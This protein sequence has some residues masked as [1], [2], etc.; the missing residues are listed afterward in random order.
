MRDYY[1]EW[2]VWYVDLSIR[3][4]AVNLIAFFQAFKRGI[5]K[6][7]IKTLQD[8]MDKVRNTGPEQFISGLASTYA[9][10]V[11]VTYGCQDSLIDEQEE[12][13]RA[14]CFDSLFKYLQESCLDLPDFVPVLPPEWIVAPSMVN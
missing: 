3:Q 5:L 10:A 14:A 1:R 8:G 13:T 6:G 4:G 12:K 9:R 7:G 2:A 11:L